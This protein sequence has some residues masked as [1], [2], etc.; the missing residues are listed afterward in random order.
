MNELAGRSVGGGVTIRTGIAPPDRLAAAG[1]WWRGVGAQVL[2]PLPMIVSPR[3]GIRWAMDAMNPDA[4]ICAHDRRGRL[5][6]LAGLRD[7]TGGLI[8]ARRPL[9]PRF[10][11][12]GGGLGRAS[13][14]LWRS[15]AGTADLILDGLIVHPHARR[16]GVAR[17]LVQAALAEVARR[18]RPGLMIE[19]FAANH[20]ACALYAAEGFKVILRCRLGHGRQALVFRR[21]R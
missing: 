8:D 18:N 4:A 3:A 5:I 12:L 13:L 9:R 2:A 7:S 20:A 15:G 11:V 16:A 14:A 17:R 10:G 19:V 21:A 6:G 1:L